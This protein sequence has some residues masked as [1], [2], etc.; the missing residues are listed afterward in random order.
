[1]YNQSYPKDIVY[2]YSKASKTYSLIKLYI[3]PTYI[4]CIIAHA[5]GPI[6]AVPSKRTLLHFQTSY[7][8]LHIIIMYSYKTRATFVRLTIPSN[9]FTIVRAT[10]FCAPPQTQLSCPRA[11]AST[12]HQICPFG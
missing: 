12:R 1:M 6:H 3:L 9:S 11:I 10:S 7:R 2:T 4:N 5:R 8:T